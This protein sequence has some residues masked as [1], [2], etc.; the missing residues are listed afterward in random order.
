MADT[1]PRSVNDRID[2]LITVLTQTI[3][4][5]Q[6]LILF[7]AQRRELAKIIMSNPTYDHMLVNDSKIRVTLKVYHRGKQYG[8]AYEFP[9]DANDEVITFL[10]ERNVRWL[11]RYVPDPTDPYIAHNRARGV[12]DV[13]YETWLVNE[14]KKKIDKQEG[15][16]A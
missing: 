8:E 10:H 4:R 3:E 14:Q 12:V 9:P 6:T 2:D 13:E 5:N 15:E 16:C 11:M 7:L 1:T